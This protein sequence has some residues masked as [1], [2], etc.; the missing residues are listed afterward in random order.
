MTYRGRI[1]HGVVVLHPAHTL[2]EGTEVEVLPLAPPTGK[3]G[4]ALEKLAG[5]ATDLP[6]DLAE[7]HDHYRRERGA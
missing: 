6:A 4:E 5:K 2:P 3:I 1:E 7:K